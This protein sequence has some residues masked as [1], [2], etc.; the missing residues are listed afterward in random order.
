[1]HV[2]SGRWLLGLGLALT[3]AVLWG[4]LPIKLKPV[5]ASMDPITVTWY[6]LI[7]A[8][9]VL[10]VWLAARKRLPSF[11][12]LDGRY[13]LLAVAIIGLV[14]NY[15]AYLMGLKRLS[16]GTTQLVIQLAP[17][18]LLLGSVVIYREE[19][20][21]AQQIGLL[22]L[23]TGFALFFNQ[24][25]VELL[26]SLTQYTAGILIMVFAALT[27]A[28]YGLAQ[29]QLLTQWSS[30]Q[31]MMVIYLGC[32]S[33]LTPWA[34]PAQLFELNTVQLWLLLACCLNTL[35]AYG[36]FAEALAHWQASRVSAMLAVTPLIT[37]A[38]AAV[39]SLIWPLWITAEPLNVLA[40]TGA[41]LVALGSAQTALDFRRVLQNRRLKRELKLAALQSEKGAH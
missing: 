40:Y 9:L 2:S 32:A 24:R 1:M 23:L 4:L 36:A 27:W 3:T 20:S 19:F 30:V 35:V 39:G 8:G 38:C 33:L 13:W 14:L 10:L 41:A 25:W 16:A 15:V 26:T 31:I 29:K 11:S 28:F 7:S 22:V 34:E 5:L 18:F 21:R 12:K 6:R 37:F 17:I